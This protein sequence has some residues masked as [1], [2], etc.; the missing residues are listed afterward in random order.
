[1]VVLTRIRTVVS[2][3]LEQGYFFIKKLKSY[4]T[5]NEWKSHFIPFFQLDFL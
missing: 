5:L 1:M 4:Y 2:S 3:D